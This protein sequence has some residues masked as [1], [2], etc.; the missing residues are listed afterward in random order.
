MKVI[1][2][3]KTLINKNNISLYLLI[4]DHN[5]NEASRKANVTYSY[6]ILL[7]KDWIEIG[8]VTSVKKSRSHKFSYTHIGKKLAEKLESVYY[9]SNEVKIL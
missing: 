9:F 3:D 4:K 5:V 2:I 6:A 8:L 1:T 7:V